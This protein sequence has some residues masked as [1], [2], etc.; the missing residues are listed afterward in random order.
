MDIFYFRPAVARKPRDY[1][2]GACPQVNRSHARA[3]QLFAALYNCSFSVDLYSRAHSAKL[4]DIA[5]ASVPY[6]FGNM[7]C[8]IRKTHKRCNLRVH[9]G[10]KAGIRKSFD[11]CRK[12]FSSAGNHNSLVIFFNLGAHFAHL[13]GDCFKVLRDYVAYIDPASG[14][15]RR[16]HKRS[17]LYHIGNDTVCT[18]VELFHALYFYNVRSRSRDIRSAEVEEV[19]KVNYVRLLCGIF[20]DGHPVAKHGSDYRIYRRADGHAVKKDVR[21]SDAALRDG[22]HTAARN[23]NRRAHGGKRLY[24]LVNRTRAEITTAG[25]SDLG[26]AVACKASPRKI[27]RRAHFSCKLKRHDVVFNASC[28]YFNGVFAD[29]AHLR[30]DA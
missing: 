13:C 25:K 20:N 24:M 17:R 27:I 30:A 29:S 21:A 18:A 28:I 15:R 4:V 3:R 19:C 14:C 26:I 11:V 8:T 16:D 23:G 5:E 2:S 12:Q 7:T 10:R 6:G 22:F 9:I 1:H